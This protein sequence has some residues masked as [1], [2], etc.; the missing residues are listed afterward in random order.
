L[1]GRERL[2]FQTQIEPLARFLDVG[3][4]PKQ[5]QATEKSFKLSLCINNKEIDLS[6]L[7]GHGDDRNVIFQQQMKITLHNLKE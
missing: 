1:L 3:Q 7:L 4:S 6:Y 5:I 2:S